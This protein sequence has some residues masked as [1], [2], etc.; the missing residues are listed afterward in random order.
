MFPDNGH[1][2]SRFV[3]TKTPEFVFITEILWRTFWHN[4]W[5]SVFDVV[6]ILYWK[7]WNTPNYADKK[8]LHQVSAYI[9]LA[10]KQLIR[11]T[12]RGFPHYEDF[13]TWKK[14]RYANF[15]WV[16]FEHTKITWILLSTY[17]IMW[18]QMIQFWDVDL[19]A[20]N[21]KFPV[22]LPPKLK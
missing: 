21:Q 11:I 17:I 7:I 2:N 1:F 13:G 22:N 20:I 9:S 18:P 19:S 12:Y 10:Y 4:N 14:S 3:L 16:K 5:R 8:F 15:A 6:K